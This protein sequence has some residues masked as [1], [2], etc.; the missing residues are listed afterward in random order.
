MKNGKLKFYIYA[1][2]CIFNIA[3][4][5]KYYDNVVYFKENPLNKNYQFK[6]FSEKNNFEYTSKTIIVRDKERLQPTFF[7]IDLP[8]MLV[9]FEIIN[10]YDFGFYY[11]DNQVIFILI[12][13]E[14]SRL[15]TEAYI[16]QRDEIE[17]LIQK[18]STS[19]NLKYDIKKNSLI[20][21][22]KFFL[23][24]KKNVSILLY[25]IKPQNFDNFLINVKSFKLTN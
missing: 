13:P 1:I 20:K 7:N 17:E 5:K 12:E 25:N 22:R 2:F 11:D 8:K 14:N 16:P 19:H 9:Y 6:S 21:N 18:V 24:K 23:M 15:D 4:N 10:I 3:C